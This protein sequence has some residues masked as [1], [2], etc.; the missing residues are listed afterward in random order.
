MKKITLSR[1]TH[2][3]LLGNYPLFS[4][5][6]IENMLIIA[7]NPGGRSAAHFDR[8]LLL[9]LHRSGVPLKQL[10]QSAMKTLDDKNF[11]LFLRSLFRKSKATDVDIDLVICYLDDT[12]KLTQRTANDASNRLSSYLQQRGVVPYQFSAAAYRKRIARLRRKGV[13]LCL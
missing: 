9:A 12:E 10:I 8:R 6:F 7:L 5:R 13:K 11:E 4:D 1:E 3:R 2:R